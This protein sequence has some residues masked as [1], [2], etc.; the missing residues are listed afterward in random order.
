MARYLPEEIYNE[1]SKIFRT[2]LEPGREGGTLNTK[3]EYLQLL[4]VAATTFLFND[5]AIYYLA[6]LSTNSLTSLVRREVA[7]LEDI[8][9]ALEDLSQIGSPVVDTTTLSNAGTALLA[10]DS[11]VS[12]KGR[13]E[14]AR[15]LNLMDSYAG[16]Q[17]QNVVSTSTGNLVRTREEAQ[18]VIRTNASRLTEI[19][20]KMLDHVQGLRDMMDDYDSLDIPGRVSTNALLNVRTNLEQLREDE[21]EWTAA[22]NLAASR[23]STL[24]ALASKVAVQLLEEFT[25][26][27]DLKYRS[28]NSPIPSTLKHLIRTTGTGE[29]A[30]A[31]TGSGPWQFP[32]S[33]SLSVTVNGGSAAT[34]DL[35]Q[36]AGSVLN[37]RNPES[38]VIAAGD[39]QRLVIV[40]DRNVYEL[41]ASSGS[42]T[43]V[44]TSEYEDFSFKHLDMP[45]FFPDMAATDP[46]PRAITELRTLQS[47]SISSYTPAT[48]TA[49]CG[50][51][52][53]VDEG[54]TQ[55]QA[56]H[57][58]CYLKD[59]SGDRFEIA[60]VVNST[61]VVL[62]V[63]VVDPVVTPSTGAAT[64]HG[65]VSTLSNTKVSF[66]PALT[67]AATGGNLETDSIDRG[68][69]SESFGD[70]DCAHQ[71]GRAAHWHPDG[72]RCH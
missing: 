49:V 6:K 26:P 20:A 62:S 58:G 2:R 32:L 54:S 7:I 33:G 9:A 3:I 38:F 14:T 4:E 66:L 24:T 27:Q 25:N 44:T 37:G 19:H 50:S 52:V 68:E 67:V 12:V 36:L 35:D 11:A 31:D 28:P 40:L 10:L 1:V 42:T 34:V 69:L 45:V 59:S 56:H 46:D 8:L 70:V 65:Q 29:P 43:E 39:Q 51:F 22:E 47:C 64:L 48:K 15:F 5:E 63:P 55:F 13:P 21:G 17:K 16:K 57:V 23:K 71:A 53:A 60:E 61:T 72:G 18:S 30:Y 41:T